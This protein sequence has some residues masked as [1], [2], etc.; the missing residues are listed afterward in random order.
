MNDHL[1]API[2]RVFFHSI[3][4]LYNFPSCLASQDKLSWQNEYDIYNLPGMKHENVLHFMGAEKRGSNLDIELWL[5]TAYHEKVNCGES[6]QIIFD[7]SFYKMSYS[8]AIM[9][10]LFTQGL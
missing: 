3:I 6:S 7:P 8:F 2:L 5:I 9:C 1:E 10:K 4:I